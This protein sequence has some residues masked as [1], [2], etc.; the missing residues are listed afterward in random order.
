MQ[1]I[2]ERNALTNFGTRFADRARDH[3]N[4]K[5]ME[6]RQ[7]LRD[8]VLHRC[9]SLLDDWLNIA[10]E[11]QRTNTT[12]QYQ[13]EVGAAKRL[14]YEPLNPE[15]ANLPPIRRRFRANR[16]MRDVE[17]SVDVTVKNL[18]DWE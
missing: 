5:S 15:L 1:I 17:P 7:A 6:A 16:S 3:N 11:F 2:A 4:T 8:K 12:L 14:L 13:M 10:T 18:N 9:T